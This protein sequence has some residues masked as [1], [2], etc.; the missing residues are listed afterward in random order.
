MGPISGPRDRPSRHKILI[1]NFCLKT[2]ARIKIPPFETTSE[3][4][5]HKQKHCKIKQNHTAW[6]LLLPGCCCCCLLLLSAAAAAAAAA[7]C[8]GSGSCSGAG[9]AKRLCSGSC[10]GGGCAKR[11]CSGSC[12]GRE[13]ARSDCRVRVRVRGICWL[14]FV[15]VSVFG[16]S[17]PRRFSFLFCFDLF[18]FCFLA[19]S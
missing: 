3:H 16:P 18:G 10:S 13:S 11:S 1:V 14:L 19:R 5:I 2:I 15:F 7:A 12:S 17:L 8:S 4:Q 9:C 6:L